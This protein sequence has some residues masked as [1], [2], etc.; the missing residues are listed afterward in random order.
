M[1]CSKMEMPSSKISIAQNAKDNEVFHKVGR[2]TIRGSPFLSFLSNLFG[3][4]QKSNGHH[5]TL[6]LKV[7]RHAIM[8]GLLA[9]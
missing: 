5:R 1:P 4:V 2:K 6:I 7:Q 8:Y 3:D 9:P